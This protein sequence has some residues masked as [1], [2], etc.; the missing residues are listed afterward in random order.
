VVAGLS[1]LS[2]GG[3]WHVSCSGRA[4]A[5]LWLHLL[6]YCNEV[7]VARK[8]PPGVRARPYGCTVID[9]LGVPITP[10]LRLLSE[11]SRSV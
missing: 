7:S 1:R 9:V 2:L 4:R 8:L 11:R 6:L 3:V 5:S 10:P